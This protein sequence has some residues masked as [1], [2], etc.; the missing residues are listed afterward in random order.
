MRN[1]ARIA[2]ILA[3]LATA[4]LSVAGNI[5]VTSPAKGTAS[6]P[7]AVK[8]ST[9][10]NF[11]IT[12]GI[13]E[14]SIDIKLFRLDTG[15]L[16]RDTPAITK[17][18]PNTDGKVTGSFTVSFSKGIDPE[19]AYRLEVRAREVSTPGN[20]YN[21]DQNLFVKPDLT[22]P[23]I[24][25]FNPLNGAFVKGVVK[26]SVKI[27]ESNL[28]DWRVQID[29]ADLPNGTGTSTDS[30]G[31]FSVDWDTSGLQFDGTKNITVRVRDDADNETNQTIT[32]AVDRV[33]PAL[34]I[35]APQNN[36]TFSPGTTLF[37]TVDVK[38]VGINVNGLDVV[39]RTTGGAFLTRVAR[40]TFS[41][42]GN[43][44]FR[45]S[46]RVRWRD[47]FLPTQ[48][49]VTASAIDRAGNVATPQS[50]TV[51]IGG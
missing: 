3:T 44:T 28:K 46:G 51:T 32:V 21:A 30:L 22:A 25:Q 34:T 33:K 14:V 18:T 20:T 13:T 7:T 5:T 35:Q 24:L 45:W 23:K 12:G 39:L 19:I 38:D 43:N 1:W 40:Q 50:V 2:A 8:A 9:T 27:S 49:K 41:S 11:N 26:I 47:N 31:Q 37:V 6:A 15:A 10:I 36:S 4:A 29:G 48:F 16:Y 17:V 42:I